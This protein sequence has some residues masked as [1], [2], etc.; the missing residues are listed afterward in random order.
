M[1]LY[2]SLLACSMNAGGVAVGR[3]GDSKGCFGSAV[4]A[5]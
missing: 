5:D 3:M 4:I 2:F 1:E